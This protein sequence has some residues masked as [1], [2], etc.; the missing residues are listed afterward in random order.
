MR[1][2][3]KLAIPDSAALVSDEIRKLLRAAEVGNRL[4]TPKADIL[5]CTNL[6]ETG[7]LDLRDY[8]LSR[9]QRVSELFY[10]AMGKLHGLL[11]RRAKLIY[12]DP[13]LHESKKNFVTYHEVTHKVLPWQNLQYTE[14]DDKSLSSECELQCEC[15]ANYGAAEILFQCDRFELEARD[16]ELSTASAGFLA[17][18]FDASY[19]SSLRRFVERN[20]RPCALLVLKSTKLLNPSGLTSFRISQVVQSS[21]FTLKFGSPFKSLFINPE[22]DLGKILNSECTGEV[23]LKDE[24][25][26]SL[27]CTVESFSNHYSRFALIYPKGTGGGRRKVVRAPKIAFDPRLIAMIV[28]AKR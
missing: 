13:E 27:E 26:F 6:I 4:P 15:E 11:D 3:P 5:Q 1:T 24:K 7:A 9:T 19:H 25:S 2:P 21:A 20:H 16:F 22:E 14:D 18:R 17:E 12:I 10:R 28:G 23:K 8:K